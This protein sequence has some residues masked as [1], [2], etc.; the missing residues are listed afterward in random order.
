MVQVRRHLDRV[1]DGLEAQCFRGVSEHGRSVTLDVASVMERPAIVSNADVMFGQDLRAAPS[2][3][4]LRPL[5]HL[6][7]RR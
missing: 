5:R 7:A 1:E 4:H 2:F 6:S 3:Q